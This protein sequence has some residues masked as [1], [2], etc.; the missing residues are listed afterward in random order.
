MFKRNTEH[1]VIVVRFDG[2]WLILDNRHLALVNAEE[3]RHYHPL[4][5]MDHRG[6]SELSTAGPRR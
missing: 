4:F 2:A 6:V 5:V 3:V 1:A